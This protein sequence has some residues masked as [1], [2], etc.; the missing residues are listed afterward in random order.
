MSRK[1]YKELKRLK[2][3]IES[4]SNSSNE[5]ISNHPVDLEECNDVENENT[6]LNQKVSRYE[7]YLDITLSSSLHSA[8]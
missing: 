8:Y 1:K 6:R 3:E 2:P 7:K 5:S 4:L